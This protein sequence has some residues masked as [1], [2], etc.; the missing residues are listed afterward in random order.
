MKKLAI[1]LISFFLM[2]SFA[3]AQA[4][5]GVSAGL[6][7]KSAIYFLD[8]LGE[9]LSLKLTFNPVKKVEKKI[10]Y[11]TERLAEL[12]TLEDEGELDKNNADSLK[13]KYK[14]LTEDAQSDSEKLKSEGKDVSGLVQKMEELTARHTAVLEKVLEKVPEQ[15][16]DAIEKA[17]EVSKR[18]HEQ[19]MEALQ[20]EVGEGKIK[21]E[22]LR[23]E[24]KMKIEEMRE[25]KDGEKLEE[26]NLD[27]DQKEIEESMKEMES[28]NGT[29]EIEK[30][31]EE[32][33]KSA[34]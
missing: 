28:G 24:V 29:S 18:G 20:K 23:E 32:A 22:E 16:R 12:K 13:D 11:A 2:F 31:L 26:L 9:W 1:P 8:T 17:L 4:D 14:K 25:K 27:Q 7:P 15:A 34:R 3:F 19:A 5:L 30:G 21:K 33:E 6:T 10:E